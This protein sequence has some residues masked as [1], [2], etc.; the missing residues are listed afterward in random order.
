MTHFNKDGFDKALA[1]G[2][3]MMVDFW[4]DWCGPC[5]MLG[6]LSSRPGQAVRG[7]GRG[8]QGERG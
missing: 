1:Q 6:P 4:A 7:Q 2:K 5:R 8:R 3:L